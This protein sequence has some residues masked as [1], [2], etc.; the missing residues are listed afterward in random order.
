MLIV[1]ISLTHLLSVM[2]VIII[3]RCDEIPTN[4]SGF[5]PSSKWITLWPNTTDLKFLCSY[6]TNTLKTRPE[7][8]GFVSQ[9]LFTPST[10]FITLHILSTLKEKCCIE[11]DLNI[12]PLWIK[13]QKCL[14]PNGVNVVIADFVNLPNFDFCSTVINLNYSSL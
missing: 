13:N 10:K 14:R 3:Y 6:L 2:Q 5:W 1:I 7:N 9:C 8:T 12:K 4:V 11:C